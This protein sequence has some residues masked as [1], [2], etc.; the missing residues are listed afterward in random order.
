MSTPI[1]I[2]MTTSAA[3]QANLQ[4][5]STAVSGNVRA[6]R[7]A[8][9][10]SPG[11]ICAIGPPPDYRARACGTDLGQ[12][13]DYVRSA[14]LRPIVPIGPHAGDRPRNLLGRR[15]GEDVTRWRSAVCTDPASSF[16]IVS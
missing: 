16:C 7:A 1:T 5:R 9:E 6:R 8:S 15:L 10:V 11:S 14:R 3:A 13:L 4:T 2:S 12:S